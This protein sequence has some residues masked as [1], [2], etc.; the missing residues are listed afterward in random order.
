MDQ[1]TSDGFNTFF[2]C[3]AAR[4]LG[5]KV[6]LSGV[7]GDE[8]FGG[9]P[10]FTRLRTLS[11]LAKLLR[12]VPATL[13]ESAS[14]AVRR[15]PKLNR[16]VHL[17]DGG[18]PYVRAYQSLRNSFPWRLARSVLSPIWDGNWC[19]PAALDNV[20]PEPNPR[21]DFFQMASLLESSV[22]MRSQLLRDMDNF[23]MAHSLELRAPFLSHQL[24]ETVYLLDQASKKS[25]EET[26]P[27][28]ANALVNPLPE[29]VTRQS[30]RGFTFPIERWLS[31]FIRRSFEDVAFDP[32][33][34][35]I[36]DQKAIRQLWTGHLAG[37]INWGMMW[38]LYAFARWRLQTCVL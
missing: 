3:R 26:K 1:P 20:Y 15:H 33:L 7:G 29:E 4:D 37:Q 25:S 36:W 28:L 19:F 31:S 11:T 21:A 14:G 38:Q 30:K 10:S 6:W 23:S 27:L 24:F 2:V 16:V 17:G 9:Y 13:L 32:A 22:Y 8:I 34:K 35:G 18:S 12:V 5:I